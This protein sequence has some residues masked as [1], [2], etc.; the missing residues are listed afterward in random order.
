MSVAVAFG[1]SKA[2]GCSLCLWLWRVA[3]LRLQGV[4]YV[5][6]CGVSKAVGCSLCLWLWR[7]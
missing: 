2:V 4:A 5:C 7:V 3:Y 1:V 6:G